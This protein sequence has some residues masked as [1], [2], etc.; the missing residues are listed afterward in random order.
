M[1]TTKVTH[2]QKLLCVYTRKLGNL[3]FCFFRHSTKNTAFPFTL[4]GF[5]TCSVLY[6][7][8]DIKEGRRDSFSEL[9]LISLW[10]PSCYTRTVKLI[11]LTRPSEL[12]RQHGMETEMRTRPRRLETRQ[13]HHH[14]TLEHLHAC[15][16]VFVAL[17]CMFF[18]KLLL[19]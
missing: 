13:D 8:L 5:G 9:V 14:L 15:V 12:Q 7:A 17:V 18:F 10:V 6:A 16:G 2:G 1:R 19:F 3:Q 4:V 11:T